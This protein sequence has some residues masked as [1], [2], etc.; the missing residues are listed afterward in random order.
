MSWLDRLKTSAYTAPDGTR[1]EFKTDDISRNFEKKSTPFEFPDVDGTYV[2]DNGASGL[3]Y[4]VEAYFT[5]DD[6]DVQA[7]QFEALLRQKGAGRLEL[8]LYKIADVVPSGTVTRTDAVKT[9]ANVTKISVTFYE[10]TL[11]VYP[12]SQVDPESE[13]LGGV[14]DSMGALADEVGGAVD[15][16][17]PVSLAT[18]KNNLKVLVTSVQNII[19]PVQELKAQVMSKVDAVLTSI[20]GVGGD[21]GVGSLMTDLLDLMATPSQMFGKIKSTYNAYDAAIKNMLISVQDVPSFYSTKTASRTMLAGLVVSVV[22]SE[23]D[24]QGSAVEMAESLLQLEE[25]ITRWEEEQREQLGIIDASSSYQSL[26]ESVA[27]TAGHLVQM[28]FTLKKE[29]KII[30]TRNRSLID[31]V[32]ELYGTVDEKLDFFIDSNSLTG[33]EILEIPK[34][35]EVVYYV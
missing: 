27:I 22:S 35:R 4:P 16:E 14:E 15:L 6:C 32:A 3:R 28:S 23:I 18:F 33:S 19:A 30:V 21:L 5:G 26:Q 17:N 31:I 25:S 34:G 24:T 20:D 9:A 13:V 11:L 7:E 1:I 10:T 2:Q 12:V 8:P 29:R